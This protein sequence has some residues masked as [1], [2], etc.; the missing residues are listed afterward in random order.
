MELALSNPVARCAK[1][2]THNPHDFTSQSVG[3]AVERADELIN[4]IA[5]VMKLL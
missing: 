1:L 2:G 5:G 4:L 3:Y